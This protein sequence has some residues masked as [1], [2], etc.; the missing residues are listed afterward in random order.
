M[1]THYRP[2]SIAALLSLALALLLAGGNRATAQTVTASR[3]EQQL[4]QFLEN[5]VKAVDTLDL[6]LV[7]KIW[8]HDPGVSFIQPRGT[9]IG[10]EQIRDDFYVKTMGLFSQRDLT[11]ENPVFHIYGDTA[12]S[13]MTWTFHATRKAGGEK[14]T[15]KGRETQIY[16]KENG[17][18]RIVHDHYSGPPVTGAKKGF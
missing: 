12:W 18:W 11:M 8:S 4:H 6:Q 1:K 17:A 16:R 13:Q 2:E 7:A 3:N 9:E 14:I 15:T 10:F 5:Y